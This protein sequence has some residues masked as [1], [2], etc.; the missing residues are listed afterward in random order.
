MKIQITKFW[1]VCKLHWNLAFEVI[2]AQIP[3]NSQ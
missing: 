3:K 2:E 1:Q